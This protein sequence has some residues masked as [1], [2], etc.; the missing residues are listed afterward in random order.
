MRRKLGNIILFM[1][2]KCK[3][4]SKKVCNYVIQYNL[5]LNYVIPRTDNPSNKYKKF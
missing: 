1:N 5:K 2:T 3:L 4:E